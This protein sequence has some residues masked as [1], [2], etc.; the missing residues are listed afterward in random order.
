ME[1]TNL[2]STSQPTNKNN[3]S[4]TNQLDNASLSQADQDSFAKT[5]KT[6]NGQQEKPRQTISASDKSK[7]KSQKTRAIDE[8]KST[9]NSSDQVVS[10]DAQDVA[11][12]INQNA[13]S[14]CIL[15]NEHV[16]L[17]KD[18]LNLVT[19]ISAEQ[20]TAIPVEIAAASSDKML[21][22][23]TD[24]FEEHD[25]ESLTDTINQDSAEQLALVAESP[26]T[27]VNNDITSSEQH[28]NQAVVQPMQVVAENTSLA[29]QNSAQ[30]AASQ[31]FAL[32]AEIA[33]GNNSTSIVNKQLN[34]SNSQTTSSENIALETNF[35]QLN[36]NQNQFS[37]LLN[38][39]NNQLNS[40]NAQLAEVK[41]PLSIQHANW[42]SALGQKVT[43]L[44]ERGMPGAKLQINPPELGPI[45]IEMQIDDS[46]AK[47]MFHASDSGV[48]SIIDNSIPKLREMLDFNGINLAHAE[49]SDYQDQ[50]STD[51]QRQSAVIS[52]N[53]REMDK[54][55]SVEENRPREILANHNLINY[56]A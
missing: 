10:N 45:Q 46:K 12:D 53:A 23:V 43:W 17:P 52:N 22:M 54:V 35:D 27:I 24:Q 15:V 21:K 55:S 38:N 13:G 8:D 1:L 34:P 41:L 50:S 29:D 56:Y 19:E 49:V 7:H 39:S 18:D 30:Q 47:I 48:R 9:V 44:V 37:T 5:L 25:S 11:T 26:A 33:N 32:T 28:I 2:V 3:S 51:Q 20:E 36:V 42:D 40:A 6:K 4:K 14:S 31:D 16:N